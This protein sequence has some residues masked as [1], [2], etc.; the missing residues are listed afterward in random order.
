MTGD[1]KV[2]PLC[3]PAPETVISTSKLSLTLWQASAKTPGHALLVPRRHIGSWFDA[4]LAEQHELQTAL[5]SV[6]DV[7]LAKYPADGFHIGFDEG[8]AQ[9]TTSGHFHIDIIP[10]YQQGLD[11]DDT[12]SEHEDSGHLADD[13]GILRQHAGICLPHH[14]SLVTGG[15]DPLYPH[16]TA[17]IAQA[18]QLD[19]AVAFIIRSG[20]ALLIEHFRDLLQRG[21]RLRLITG[22]YFDVTEPDAL[23]TL[24]DL[25]QQFP[26]QLELHVFSNTAS[27]FHPKAYLLHTG[28][29]TGIAFVGSS[30]MSR[31]A[32]ITGLEWNYRTGMDRVTTRGTFQQLVT[33]FDRLLQHPAT[34]DLNVAWVDS[35]RA[36][37]PSPSPG[38]I[39]QAVATIEP[40]TPPPAPH[41]IQTTALAAL[42]QTRVAGNGAGLVV[43]A[44]GL[45]KTWLAAFDSNRTDFHRVLFVAHRQE[46]LTQAMATFRRIRPQAHLGLY[47]GAR[48]QADADV[49]FASIQ[50]IGRQGHLDRFAPDSFDYIIVDEFHHASARTYRRLL[51]HFE[52]KFLLGLTA[53]PERTDGGDLLSLCQ[54]NLVYRCT[55]FDGIR[56]QLLAPFHYFGIPD[57][58]DYSNIPWRGTRFDQ[59]ELTRAVATRRRAGNILAQYRKRAGSRTLGFCVSRL[60]ANFMKEYFLAEGIEAAAVHSGTDSD[61]RTTSLERLAAG[62]LQIV[63]AVDM[64]NE[65]VDIPAIDTVLMLRPT[66]SQILWLQQFGRGLRRSPGKDQLTVI[67]YIGNHR[68]FLTK[69]KALLSMQGGTVDLRTWLHALRTDRSNTKDIGLPPSCAVTYELGVIDVLNALLPRQSRKQAL[70]D[71]YRSFKQEQ[72]RRPTATETFHDGFEP[73]Q[74]KRVAASWFGLVAQEDDLHAADASVLESEDAAAFLRNLETTPMT[75]SFKMLVLDAMLE[76]G[77]FPGALPIE[78]LANRVRRIAARSA[79]LQRELGAAFGDPAQLGTLLER[80]PIRAWCGGKGTGGRRFFEYSEQTLRSRLQLATDHTAA[81]REMVEEMTEWRMAEYLARSHQR[82]AGTD[83]SDASNAAPQTA[84]ILPFR[85]VQ[86]K[87][88]D[89]FDSCVPLVTLK[90]AAGGFG[91]AMEVDEVDWVQPNTRDRL[92]PGMFIAQVV[93]HSMEP[94]IPDGAYGLFRTPVTGSRSGKILLLQHRDIHDPETGG[95]YTVKVFDSRAVTGK[96]AENRHG[97]IYLRPLNP[98][99]DPIVL[100]GDGGEDKV[101]V[102]AELVEVLTTET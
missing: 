4:T 21:G 101:R 14:R 45:G 44:T 30:N 71:Y 20:V 97:T 19:I 74:A 42:E 88:D 13:T 73:R 50:T 53:T 65:G 77:Q 28:T 98:D 83:A 78:E 3:S 79:P 81:L 92:Q 68:S 55:V 59:A 87:P 49:L 99:Y 12:N 27:G 61:P 60:H 48:R 34:V 63:F 85:R 93:G 100:Q 29:D 64:F 2:C 1:T 23:L 33:A 5:R 76:A 72:G 7:V 67:D 57:D 36:R 10:R 69:P 94:R 82:A 46:I 96:E 75:R 56:A 39:A 80:N 51:A 40:A 35:Y 70:L 52:P 22:D 6:R 95:S 32:L 38:D 89:Y 8:S 90:A 62:D 11:L 18:R 16:L 66:E 84:D 43:L 91:D 9:A 24:L 25:A 37:R 86:A 58:V 54:E 102:I 41:P 15:D 26:G 17:H 47:I 31:N